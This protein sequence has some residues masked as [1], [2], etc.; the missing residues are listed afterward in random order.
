MSID[1]KDAL[2]PTIAPVIETYLIPMTPHTKSPPSADAA[3]ETLVTRAKDDLAE[4]LN[5]DFSEIS[6]LNADAV[7]WADGSLGCPE[8]GM[9]Y[10]QVITPGY[11]I[12]LEANG[13]IFE[14][15]ASRGTEV[16]YCKNPQPPT[17]GAPSDQ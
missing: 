10:A 17:S 5:I 1:D 13:A 15:H 4:R 16:V 12:R 11:L 2:V 8:P 3:L 6:L 7:N 14:Y 9:L